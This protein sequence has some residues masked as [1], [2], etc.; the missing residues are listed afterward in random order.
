MKSGNDEAW[1]VVVDTNIWISF[2]IG[3]R[4][5]G[6]HRHMDSGRIRIVTCNEQL[7]E[8]ANV[9][10]RPRIRKYISEE[11]AEE[12]L[13]L[14]L[15]VAMLV[16]PE[17]GPQLCR[18]PKDDYL[19][20]TAKA[21]GADYLVSGDNDLLSLREIGSTRIVSYSDFELLMTGLRTEELP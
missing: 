14:L 20:Y 13:D 15:D 16:E 19:L 6:L 10:C 3:K 11:Q 1:R 5:A 4:L 21:A 17:A 9:L 7:T 12:F 18:D 8:I 2:L